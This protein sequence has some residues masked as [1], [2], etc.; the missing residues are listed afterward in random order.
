MKLNYFYFFSIDGNGPGTIIGQH[1]K[2]LINNQFYQLSG[3]WQVDWDNGKKNLFY[4]MG[5][6]GKYD[7][8]ILNYVQKPKPKPKLLGSLMFNAMEFVD[9]KI[10]CG[11]KT[12]ECHR[13]VLACQSD[14][15]KAML[16]NKNMAEA[17]SGQVEIMDFD[18]I[19]IETMLYFLYHEE[20]KVIFD[21]F[22]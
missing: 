22:C 2:V 3:M 17:K 13:N 14:V 18:A 4:R 19:T 20:I 16:L 6:Y 21:L 8:K 7:L 5:Q 12:F 9:F 15:F 1:K 11:D 10:I